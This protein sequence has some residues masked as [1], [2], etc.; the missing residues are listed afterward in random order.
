MRRNTPYSEQELSDMATIEIQFDGLYAYLRS[1]G[2]DDIWVAVCAID[3][4]TETILDDPNKWLNKFWGDLWPKLTLCL[5]KS[6]HD[7]YINRELAVHYDWPTRIA[8]RTYPAPDHMLKKLDNGEV[9]MW[10]DRSAHVAKP[11]VAPAYQM[12]DR[13]KRKRSGIEIDNPDEIMHQVAI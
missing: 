7:F 10:F 2:F 5:A 4:K 9:K 6:K 11:H 1:P 8:L 12:A 3:T 13:P